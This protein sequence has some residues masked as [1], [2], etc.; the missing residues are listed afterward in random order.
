MHTQ[1]ILTFRIQNSESIKTG[2]AFQDKKSNWINWSVTHKKK[3]AHQHNFYVKSNDS[4]LSSS[5]PLALN[6][7][8]AHAFYGLCN[9]CIL[10]FVLQA[11]SQVIRHMFWFLVLERKHSNNDFLFRFHVPKFNCKPWFTSQ[12]YVA[13]AP[14]QNSANFHSQLNHEKIAIPAL[15]WNRNFRHLRD[16]FL[17][18]IPPLLVGTLT[19]LLWSSKNTNKLGTNVIYTKVI[20]TAKKRIDNEQAPS[21]VC[22][23][24]WNKWKGKWKKK[25]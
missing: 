16:E 6:K 13:Q 21:F 18:C 19:L 10:L 17:L 11:H 22:F 14:F 3:T 25:P 4:M 12:S 5:F 20:Q 8:V 1:V 9:T 24:A 7:G 23:S 2:R 15:Y